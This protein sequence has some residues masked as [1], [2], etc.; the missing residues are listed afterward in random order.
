MKMC[1]PTGVFPLSP[2]FRILRGG[3]SLPPPAKIQYA[4]WVNTFFMRA[5][6]SSLLSLLLSL[7]NSFSKWTKNYLI[8]FFNPNPDEGG[9]EDDNMPRLHDIR[10]K[11]MTEEKS[12]GSY[13]YSEIASL[14]ASI[15]ELSFWSDTAIYLAILVRVISSHPG[16]LNFESRLG[17]KELQGKGKREKEE[18]E[19]RN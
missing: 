18:T 15:S 9:G 16:R 17:L 3:N 8:L 6:S 2:F 13:L 5:L 11:K 10:N 19:Q 14:T 12:L 4:P 1:K 7:L